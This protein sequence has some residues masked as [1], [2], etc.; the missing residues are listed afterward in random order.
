M[1]AAAGLYRRDGSDDDRDRACRVFPSN[2]P[3]THRHRAVGLLGQRDRLPLTFPAAGDQQCAAVAD[4]QPV[5]QGRFIRRYR[6][7]PAGDFAALKLRPQP[8]S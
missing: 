5:G 8:R 2:A 7:A 6:P 1:V 4:R 3:G